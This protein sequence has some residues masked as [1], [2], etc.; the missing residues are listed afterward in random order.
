MNQLS[1]RV[2]SV[3]NLDFIGPVLVTDLRF[4]IAKSGGLASREWSC[5]KFAMKTVASAFC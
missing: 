4:V 1:G 5:L 3:E 2:G